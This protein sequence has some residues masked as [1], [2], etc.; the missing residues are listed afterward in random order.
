MT[1]D[2]ENQFRKLKDITLNNVDTFYFS[3]S[4]YHGPV[5]PTGI[6]TFG[7]D[8]IRINAF[9]L[10]EAVPTFYLPIVSGRNLYEAVIVHLDENFDFKYYDPEERVLGELN[11]LIGNPEHSYDGTIEQARIYFEMM[12][13][14]FDIVYHVNSS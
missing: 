10:A 5:S 2:I 12:N 9:V 13:W 14:T 7:S 4:A 6:V 11:V 1:N 3:R 8:I